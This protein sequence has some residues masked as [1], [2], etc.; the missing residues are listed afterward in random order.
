MEMI[1]VERGRDEEKD[2][3]DRRIYDLNHKPT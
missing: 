2:K 3:E 1:R